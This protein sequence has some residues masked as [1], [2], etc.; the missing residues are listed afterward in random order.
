MF[1]LKLHKTEMMIKFV[2]MKTK[3]VICSVSSDDK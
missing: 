2:Y 1:L 3:P